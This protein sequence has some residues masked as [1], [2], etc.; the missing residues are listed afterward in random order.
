MNGAK[1]V[2][3]TSVTEFLTEKGNIVGIRTIEGDITCEKLVLCCGQWTRE[4]AKQVGVTVPL[5]SVEHQYM[6]TESFGVPSDLPTVMENVAA[7]YHRQVMDI[8]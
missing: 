3:N 6:I 8:P 2:E 7:G 5:V 1:L 4:L